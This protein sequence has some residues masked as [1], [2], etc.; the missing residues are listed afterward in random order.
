MHIRAAR[1][2]DWKVCLALEV[3]YETEA[4]WQMEESRS[5]GEWGMR[6]REVR[7]P[8]KQ[9]MA[10][11]LL[12]EQ[13]LKGWQRCTAFWVAIERQ[14]VAGYAGVLLEAE[15]HQAT[16]AELAVAAEHR[17]Q[18]IGR[19]LLQHLTEWSQRQEVEQLLLVCGLKAQPAIAFAQ[20]N[21]F[22]LCGFQSGYWPGQEVGLFFHKRLR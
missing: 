3:A 16:I 9:R 11:F 20:A 19:Q 4:A 6:F 14:K 22:T 2:E 17:R 18:G 1:N 7:L 10:P 5:E 13:R 12:P 21:G 15:R 8:R